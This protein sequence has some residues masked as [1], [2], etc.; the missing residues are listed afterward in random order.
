MKAI[1]TEYR[2]YRM[3]SRVEARWA[4]F[5]DTLDIKWEYESE[6]YDLDGTYYLPDFWAMQR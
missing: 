1:E 6:G 3:R 5:F 4:V 2:G